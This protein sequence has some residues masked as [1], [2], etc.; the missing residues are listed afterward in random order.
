MGAKLDFGGSF[1]HHSGMKRVLLTGAVLAMTSSFL[2]AGSIWGDDYNREDQEEDAG[3]TFMVQIN[4]PD[5]IYGFCFGSGTWLKGTP[6]F[7][8]FG[9]DMLSNG[10]ED[11]WYA[12]VSMTIRIMPHWDVA[13]FIGAGGA[14]HRSANDNSTNSPK[15]VVAGEPAD[16]GDSYWGWHAEAGIRFWLP[17]RVRLVELMGRYVWTGLSGDD[18]DYWVAGIATGTGF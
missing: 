15:A 8:D 16:R 12:G 13:P 10:K 14:Y 5:D 1:G 2:L 9:V 17:N 18:R 7:G 6:I 11:E 3:A 4:P